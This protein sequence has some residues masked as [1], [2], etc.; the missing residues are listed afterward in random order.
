MEQIQ[1]QHKILE[2]VRI[3]IKHKRKKTF[4]F[5]NLSTIKKSKDWKYFEDTIN[6]FSNNEEWDSY[7]YI[8]TL[9]EEYGD[10]WPAQLPTNKSWKIYLDNRD[11]FEKNITKEVVLELLLTY[12]S[13]KNYCK[14]Y[15]NDVIDY[16]MYL[17]KERDKILRGNINPLLFLFCKDFYVIF[18]EEE[19]NKIFPNNINNKKMSIIYNNDV[20]DKIK[21]VLGDSYV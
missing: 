19:I 13:V 9:F 11:R 14:K 8:A 16:S 18:T 3:Y 4:K 21:K 7:K 15:N 1:I 2:L 5:R 6:N 17:T 20:R 12:K 10:V